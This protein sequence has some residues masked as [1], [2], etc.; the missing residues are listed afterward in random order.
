[1]N[2]VG[3]GFP[4]TSKGMEI[5]CEMLNI[6]EPEIWAVLT[7]ETRGFGYLVDR[8]PQILF[9]RHIFSKRTGHIYDAKHSDISGQ[10]GGYKGGRAEYDRL[11][12]AMELDE[13]EAL[14]SASWG[15][16]QVMGFNHRVVNKETVQE[17]VA[18]MVESEDLQL[19]ALGNFI[20]GNPKCRIGIQRRD[21]GTFAACYN[22][23]N[24]R[25]N[26]Y[27]NRLAAAYEKN[28]RILP[29]IGLRRAQVALKYLGFNPGAI[30]GLRGR[31]TRGAMADFQAKK[32]LA[33]TGELDEETETILLKN[34]FAA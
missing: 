1:M 5:V 27:D 13:E 6:G 11:E 33:P 22:G 25:R 26:D 9:E 23:P 34:A 30:D 12:K 24:F 16:P 31:M 17:M 15:L 28:R 3:N 18:G 32:E 14:K 21:W 4:M 7:V 2:F 8:R 10:P 20:M 29:D 19:E